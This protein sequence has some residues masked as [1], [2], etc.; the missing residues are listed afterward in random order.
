VIVR[1]PAATSIACRTQRGAAL[2][3]GLL[4]LVVLTVLAISGLS[5]ATIELAMAGNNQH[6]NRAFEAA[7]AVLESE[8]R[9]TDLAPLAAPGNLASLA[10]NV[11]RVFKDNAGNTVATA[12]AGTRFVATTGVAGWQLGAGHSFSAHHFE[13]QANG[14]SARGATTNQLQGYYVVGP[15]N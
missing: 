9:R 12:T 1:A 3:V 15:G 7:A 2:I 10:A 8:I 14:T 11:G 13:G 6:S 4:M 5:T